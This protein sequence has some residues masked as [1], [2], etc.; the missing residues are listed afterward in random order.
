MKN[1]IILAIFAF[2][3]FQLWTKWGNSVTP[4]FDEPYIA[5]YGR[6]ACGVTQRMLK[7]L[8][9]ANIQYHYYSVDDQQVADD[10]HARMESSGIST[11]RYN[12]PVVDVSGDISVRPASNRV[13]AEY[14]F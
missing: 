9:A 11:R 6:N 12:L 10:L 8:S 1:I 7:D 14:S 3:A 13:I 5:V 2:G 4:S